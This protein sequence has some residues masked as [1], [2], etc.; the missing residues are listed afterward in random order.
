MIRYKNLEWGNE[1]CPRN[2]ERK[3]NKTNKH[4]N[5]QKG[6]K[7]CQVVIVTNS[8]KIYKQPVLLMTLERMVNA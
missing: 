8:V 4:E 6:G 1:R 2:R 3:R 7:S 5:R